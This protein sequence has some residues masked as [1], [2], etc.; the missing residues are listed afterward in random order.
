[1]GH[2]PV[3]ESFY[4]KNEFKGNEFEIWGCDTLSVYGGNLEPIGNG[5]ML[6][7]TDNSDGDYNIEV[8]P[9]DKNNE[10]AW[11]DACW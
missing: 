6:L 10:L 2:T 11:R 5:D 9:F 1:M 8:V 4:R 7:A 3:N